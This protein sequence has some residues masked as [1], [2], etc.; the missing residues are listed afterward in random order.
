MQSNSIS[1]KMKSNASVLKTISVL[2][3]AAF[4]SHCCNTTLSQEKYKAVKAVILILIIHF[5]NCLL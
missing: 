3:D 5:D 2:K 4:K 1:H